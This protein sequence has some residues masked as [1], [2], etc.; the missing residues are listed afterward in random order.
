MTDCIFFFNYNRV[1]MKLGYPIMDESINEFFEADRARRLR[2]EIKAV[3]P[4]QR[5]EK[6]LA[7]IETA[8]R[9]AHAF[10]LCFRFRTRHGGTSHHLIYASKNAAALGMMK[11]I[12]TKAS[13]DKVEGV[14]SHH[15]DPRDEHGNLS[16]FSGLFPVKQRLQ[17]T[18]AGKSLAF[19]ELLDR[20]V[21]TKFTITNYRD[22][23]LELESEGAVVV[24]PPAEVRPFQAGR[25]KRTLARTSRITFLK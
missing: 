11:R 3:D 16:L 17:E 22:A 2:D 6:V 24:D 19:S 8:L 7:S 18:F 21:A 4:S 15:F 12:M 10:P 20:E 23:L 25:E 5:E 14:G 1:N 13:S 9:D